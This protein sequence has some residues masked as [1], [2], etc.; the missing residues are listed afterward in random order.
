MVLAGAFYTM[1]KN[2][3]QLFEA[4]ESALDYAHKIQNSKMLSSDSLFGESVEVLLKEPESPNV[5]QWNEK[6]FLH[7]KEK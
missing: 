7:K 1:N 6:N 5:K 3:A 2:R 4:V